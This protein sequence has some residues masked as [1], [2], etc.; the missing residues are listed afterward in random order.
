MKENDGKSLTDR[1][2][3]LKLAGLGTVS[4]GVALV[5]GQSPAAAENKE[6]REDGLYQET[7][8]VKTYYELA[9]N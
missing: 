5:T 2:N 4:G 7:E 1:R 3:F 8:H 9:R 6:H